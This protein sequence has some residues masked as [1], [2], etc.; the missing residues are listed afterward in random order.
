[1]TETLRRN[2][3]F[4]DICP[5][6]TVML[7]VG[8]NDVQSSQ[9]IEDFER[10]YQE[11]ITL[12][13]IRIKPIADTHLIVF[14]L[15]PRVTTHTRLRVKFE[16]ANNFL[17]TLPQPPNG[18]TTLHYLDIHS[19]MLK[20]HG[21]EIRQNNFVLWLRPS[22]DYPPYTPDGLHLSKSGMERVHTKASI[23]LS[24]IYPKHPCYDMAW[25]VGR[26]PSRNIRIPKPPLPFRH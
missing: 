6:S 9:S 19:M 17:R 12:V 23:L 1:M 24:E 7:W 22:P 14:S 4:K 16:R 25:N 21:L 18:L 10:N 3:L 8:G 2:P 13:Q 11:L 5:F 15:P 26:R 20:N